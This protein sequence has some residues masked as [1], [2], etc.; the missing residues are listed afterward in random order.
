PSQ[1][2][3]RCAAG[4]ST[5]PRR[6]GH[7]ARGGAADRGARAPPPRA[8]R[9]GAPDRRPGSHPRGVRAAQHPR[10][11]RGRAH[12]PGRGGPHGLPRRRGREPARLG[13]APR[14]RARA[15]RALLPRAED[16]RVTALHA[17]SLREAA[18]RVRRREV[19]A[20]ELVR[21]AFARIA[22][23]DGRVGAF[24]TLDE[25]GALATAAAVD[26]RVAAGE[27]PGPLG[28]VPIGVKDVICTAGLRTTAGSRILERFVP[29]YDA[30]VTARLPAAFCGVAGMKP[31]YGRVSRYGVIAY[32]SSLDQVGPIAREVADVAVVLEAIAG[33]DPADS[34]ASPRPVPSYAAALDGSVRGLRLGLPREYFVEGMQADV[35]RGVRAAVAELE[36]LGAALEP[37]SLPPTESAR[38]TYYLT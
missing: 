23:V 8:R 38:A 32:A 1:G 2:S 20:T 27:E 17:L 7:H 4:G 13:G 33:H 25:A 10:H 9:G 12:R 28:G 35:E 29:S 34:T 30:T 36:R 14:Q 15:R 21:D 19:S 24:L 37:G 31:T 22:A 11:E 26:R 6:G 18:A 3:R 16:H 5:L